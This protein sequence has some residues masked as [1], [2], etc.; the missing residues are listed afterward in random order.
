MFRL[1]AKARNDSRETST[2]PNT[3]KRHDKVCGA[4]KT[5]PLHSIDMLKGYVVVGSI[6]NMI[7]DIDRNAVR[8]HPQK[9]LLLSSSKLCDTRCSAMQSLDIRD[10][11]RSVHCKCVRRRV[12]QEWTVVSQDWSVRESAASQEAFVQHKREINKNRLRQL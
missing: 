12:G 11:P 10:R 8:L 4:T 6:V 5:R 7:Y 2:G 1:L 3:M 9:K